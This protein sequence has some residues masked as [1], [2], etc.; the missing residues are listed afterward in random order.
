[1][2]GEWGK[3]WLVSNWSTKFQT[4]TVNGCLLWELSDNAAA[5]ASGLAVMRK[6][7]NREFQEILSEQLLWFSLAYRLFWIP[8][9]PSGCILSSSS[10]QQPSKSA[11]KHHPLH[12]P[13]SIVV[14]RC[15]LKNFFFSEEITFKYKLLVYLCWEIV[16]VFPSI[17][18]RQLLSHDAFP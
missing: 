18:V 8:S 10:K 14:Q 17:F 7:W 12:H 16:S 13:S 4:K 11:L 1:M 6:W 5:V 9:V 15:R 2:D 3:D